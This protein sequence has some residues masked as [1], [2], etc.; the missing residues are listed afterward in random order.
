M[1]LNGRE[2]KHEGRADPWLAELAQQLNG[3][4]L[5]FSE[6]RGRNATLEIT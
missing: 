2:D 3:V 6:E 4:L 5:R 1:A